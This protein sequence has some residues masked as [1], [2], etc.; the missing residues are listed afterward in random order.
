M[1]SPRDVHEVVFLTWCI[2]CPA[3]NATW[4]PKSL[5]PLQGHAGVP[6]G[7][8]IARIGTLQEERKPPVTAALRRFA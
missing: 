2:A 4:S 8:S 6:S 1:R 5:E 3:S 7:F